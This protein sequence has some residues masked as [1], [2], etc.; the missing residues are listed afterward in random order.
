MPSQPALFPDFASEA[1]PAFPLAVIELGTSAIRM[2]IGVTDG[3]DTVHSVEQLVQGV[4]LG[5]DTFTGGVIQRSTQQQ[6]VD[7][8]KTYRRKLEEYQCTNPRHI[9]VV[10]TS[11][12]REAQNRMAFLDRIYAATGFNVEQIDDADI[13]RVTYLAMRPILQAHPTLQ[14]ATT[15]LMEVG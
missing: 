8:L 15:M 13:A 3:T 5:K 7:V 14:N 4:S 9:R 1:S 10:A 6:C 2:A 12:V 11:A